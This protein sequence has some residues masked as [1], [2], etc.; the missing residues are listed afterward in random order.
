MS[1][2]HRVL[3]LYL[4]NL[5]SL[6]IALLDKVNSM[7]TQ[8][9]AGQMHKCTDTCTRGQIHAHVVIYMHIYAC[10]DTCT[11]G[12]IHT[13]RYIPGQIHM[14]SDIQSYM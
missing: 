10:S 14:W 12:Q 4:G 9:R 11:Y 5:Y 6:I 7:N 2:P 13:V 1:G 8:V 3:V